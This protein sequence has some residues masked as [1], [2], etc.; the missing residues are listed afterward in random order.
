MSRAESEPLLSPFSS[1]AF[2]QSLNYLS[3]TPPVTGR[4][5]YGPDNRQLQHGRSGQRGR[6]SSVPAAKERSVV[7]FK[8]PSNLTRRRND[9]T[10]ALLHHKD[11][12]SPISSDD[13]REDEGSSFYA[14]YVQYDQ[15]FG[16]NG[17]SRIS[18]RF[19][20]CWVDW[21][22]NIECFHHFFNLLY[23]SFAWKMHASSK[24]PNEVV[25]RYWEGSVWVENG[26]L[27]WVRFPH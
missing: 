10:Q 19:Q 6:S 15:R 11:D 25:F 2:Q 20:E 8:S 5:A 9:E 26:T 13:E 21:R 14:S 12:M 7:D 24:S 18:V 23:S 16:W 17:N 4:S 27:H 1:P 3:R 22:W